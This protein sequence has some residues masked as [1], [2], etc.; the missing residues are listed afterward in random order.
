MWVTDGKR[1]LLNLN[2]ADT[3]FSLILE[4]NN[5]TVVYNETVWIQKSL[6]YH[7]KLGRFV[8]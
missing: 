7:P 2:G 5:I 1:R 3:A 6:Q 4:K 8:F